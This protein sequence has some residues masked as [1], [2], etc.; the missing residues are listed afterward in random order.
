MHDEREV[1]VERVADVAVPA[2]ADNTDHEQT[3]HEGQHTTSPGK[4]EH[5]HQHPDHHEGHQHSHEERPVAG[6]LV[7]AHEHRMHRITR[8]RNR[9]RR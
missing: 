2:V 9:L 1:V 6:F 7:I 5:D 3:H 4:G 8:A